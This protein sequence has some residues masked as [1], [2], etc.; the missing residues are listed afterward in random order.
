MEKISNIIAA[1]EVF[2]PDHA[3]NKHKSCLNRPEST[4]KGLKEFNQVVSDGEYQIESMSVSSSQYSSSQ[5]SFLSNHGA[6]QPP[7]RC[8]ICNKSFKNNYFLQK[9][10]FYD[11][12]CP[13]LFSCNIPGCK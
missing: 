2:V 6:Q 8:H 9:H 3:P 12:K 5:F 1:T 13:E 11:H 7:T 4:P 10:Q